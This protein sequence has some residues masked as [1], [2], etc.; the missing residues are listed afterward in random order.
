MSIIFELQN[1]YT[2]DPNEPQ[3]VNLITPHDRRLV[4]ETELE[5]IRQTDTPV[6]I[7]GS[8]PEDFAFFASRSDGNIA[9]EVGYVRTHQLQK[10]LGRYVSGELLLKEPE[11]YLSP[12]LAQ[13]ITKLAHDELAQFDL[14]DLIDI[15]KRQFPENKSRSS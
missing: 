5:D 9:D 14:S 10:R 2:I 1:M 11:K 12:E 4:G 7:T 8:R 13:R 3:K 15:A 6:L